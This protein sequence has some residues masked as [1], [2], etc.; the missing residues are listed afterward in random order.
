MQVVY[1]LAAIIPCI[2]D[3]AITSFELIA[4][5]EVCGG[6]HQMAKQRLVFGH[7]FCLGRDMLLRD[8]QQ[9]D[10]RLRVDV[11]ETN[12]QLIFE[13][14]VG[15]YGPGDDLAKQTI[16]GHLYFTWGKYFGCWPG[17]HGL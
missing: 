4:A 13:H 15:W 10:G 12:A 1:G 5:R 14:A 11:R 6:R 17:A 7:S 8:E 9:M 16:V 2:D 3:D